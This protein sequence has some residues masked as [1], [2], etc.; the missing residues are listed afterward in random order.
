MVHQNRAAEGD[1]IDRLNHVRIGRLCVQVSG[2][3]CREVDGDVSFLPLVEIF[4]LPLPKIRI[5]LYNKVWL[6]PK[7]PQDERH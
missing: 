1:K 4:L 6:S 7:N 2:R 3:S 5:T